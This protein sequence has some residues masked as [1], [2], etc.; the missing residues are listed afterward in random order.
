MRLVW[1][2]LIGMVL[3]AVLAVVQC[4]VEAAYLGHLLPITV[5][6]PT[7]AHGMGIAAIYVWWTK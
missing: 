6:F 3:M 1:R 5:W 4:A 7:E 2:V